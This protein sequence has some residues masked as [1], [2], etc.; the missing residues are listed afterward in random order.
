M[1]SKFLPPLP[2]PISGKLHPY[3]VVASDLL[4]Q[5]RNL[6]PKSSAEAGDER[7]VLYKQ[8]FYRQVVPKDLLEKGSYLYLNHDVVGQPTRL[9]NVSKRLVLALALAQVLKARSGRYVNHLVLELGRDRAYASKENRKENK[10]LFSYVSRV[11]TYPQPCASSGIF[12]HVCICPF[13]VHRAQNQ[14]DYTKECLTIGMGS[15]LV[16]SKCKRYFLTGRSFP[17][18]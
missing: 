5:V 2:L 12:Y 17:Q 16:P 11:H 18:K 13:L 10:S 3:I 14:T 8:H 9:H 1:P 4:Y 6:S 15:R 7:A